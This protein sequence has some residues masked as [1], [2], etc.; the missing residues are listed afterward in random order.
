VNGVSG[1]IRAD[2]STNGVTMSIDPFLWDVFK[3]KKCLH[4]GYS[5]GLKNESDN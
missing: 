1:S 3:V 4:C 5:R 2:G